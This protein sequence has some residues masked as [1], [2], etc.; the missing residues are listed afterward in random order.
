M[1]I[2][3]KY[4]GWTSHR[5]AG[6]AARVLLAAI[7]IIIGGS[8]LLNFAGTSQFLA[9]A[10]LPVPSVLTA[11]AIVFELGGGLMLLIGWKKRLAIVMLAAFTVAATLLFNI[12][13]LT[14]DQTQTVNFLKNL[15]ILGG[16]LALYR[17]C[18]HADCATCQSEAVK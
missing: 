8:K 12:K 10:G 13:N 16:L 7:F 11:L 2:V 17:S 18:G 1:H 9:A 15:A 14:T 5:Y 6:I 4:M 3:D